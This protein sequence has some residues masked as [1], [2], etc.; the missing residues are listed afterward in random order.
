MLLIPVGSVENERCF[1]LMN[2]L[3]S[4]LRNRLGE[5]H[6][7]C[8]VRVKRCRFGLNDFPFNEALSQWND[9]VERR[10]I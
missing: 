9:M 3:K 8:C 10:Q 4:D 2:L 6:L 7:N 5:D 1:S